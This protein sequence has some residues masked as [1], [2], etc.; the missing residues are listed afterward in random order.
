MKLS[1][2]FS[3]LE[4][5]VVL[6]VVGLFSAMSVAWLDAGP[7]PVARALDQLA[8]EAQGTAARARHSGQILGLRWNGR[9]PEF[10]HLQ[11][12]DGAARWIVEPSGLDPWP[13]QLLADWPSSSTPGVIFTPAG[14]AGA[15][16]LNWRWEAGQQRWDWRTDNS[17]IRTDLP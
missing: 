5:L 12:G 11:A 2:G 10:V 4:I 14:V 13:Q 6:L 7:A 8:A 9:E 1:R 16:N 15:A 17:L 3:L